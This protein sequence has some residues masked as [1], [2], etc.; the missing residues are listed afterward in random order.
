M[1]ISCFVHRRMQLELRQAETSVIEEVDYLFTLWADSFDQ[2]V[3]MKQK[4]ERMQ[5]SSI[6]ATTLD[7]RLDAILA[8][9]LQHRRSLDEIMKCTRFSKSEIRLLYR[10]FKQVRRNRLRCLDTCS[11]IRRRN[12][13]VAT[14][15]KNACVKSTCNSFRKEVRV[16]PPH[17]NARQFPSSMF[18]L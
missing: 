7:A 2:T 9:N 5:H 14:S 17:D 18:L 6:C 1:L 13:Q 11:F 12:V 10:S 15:V 4:A 3:E 16:P 8:K